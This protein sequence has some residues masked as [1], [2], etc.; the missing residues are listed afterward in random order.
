MQTTGLELARRRTSNHRD[1]SNHRASKANQAAA[2]TR[3]AGGAR[4]R[5]DGLKQSTQTLRQKTPR[6]RAC[7]HLDQSRTYRGPWATR[8]HHS[9]RPVSLRQ[10]Y[11][12][13]LQAGRGSRQGHWADSDERADTRSAAKEKLGENAEAK[14]RQGHSRAVT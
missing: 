13:H 5:T 12:K 4:T 10:A 11:R 2:T 8:Q 14:N 9:E 3:T 1:S 7:E 6:P